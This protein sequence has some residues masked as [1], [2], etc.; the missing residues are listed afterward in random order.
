MFVGE[1][2]SA[3]IQSSSEIN[4]LSHSVAPVDSNGGRRFAKSMSPTLIVFPQAFTLSLSN[5]C[6]LVI[7]LVKDRRFLGHDGKPDIIYRKNR[8]LWLSIF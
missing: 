7:N 1:P 2:Y 8:G 5:L 4:S 3:T 6:N